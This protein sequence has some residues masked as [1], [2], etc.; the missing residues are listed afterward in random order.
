M[1]QSQIYSELGL[2]LVLAQK[3]E[4]VL[5]VGDQERFIQPQH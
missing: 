4:H 3:L 2:I 5:H 1:F